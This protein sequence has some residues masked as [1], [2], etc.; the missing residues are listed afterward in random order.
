MICTLGKADFS[1]LSLHV[2]VPP[3]TRDCLRAVTA[4]GADSWLVTSLWLMLGEAL[5][6]SKPSSNTAMEISPGL[7]T[8]VSLAVV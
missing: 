8:E 7:S 5:C 2:P 6:Q 1:V 3:Q 4:G